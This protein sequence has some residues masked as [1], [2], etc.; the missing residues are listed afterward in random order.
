MPSSAAITKS[1]KSMPG[2]PSHHVLDELF[3][4]RHVDY[5]QALAVF[6]IVKREPQFYCY[7]PLLLLDQTVAVD[8]CQGLY[9]CRLAVVDMPGGSPLLRASSL[10][11]FISNNSN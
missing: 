10:R 2:R 3:M 8:S 9:Q 5:S 1:T 11:I 6:H 4:A 7:A